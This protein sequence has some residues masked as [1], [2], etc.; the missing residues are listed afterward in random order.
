MLLNKGQTTY[1]YNHVDKIRYSIIDLT[2]ASM[3][4]NA[5]EWEVLE[6]TSCR[7]DHCPIIVTYLNTLT[8]MLTRKPNKFRLN[9]N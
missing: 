8:D 5:L 1:T 4:L 3:I 9:T 2:L 6:D 7:S